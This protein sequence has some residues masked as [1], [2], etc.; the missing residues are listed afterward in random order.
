MENHFLFFWFRI[1]FGEFSKLEE[2]FV[3]QFNFFNSIMYSR[4]NNY[5]FNSLHQRGQLYVVA[6]EFRCLLVVQT[7]PEVLLV[8]LSDETTQMRRYS[9]RLCAPHWTPSDQ[10]ELSSKAFGERPMIH[11]P[12]YKLTFCNLIAYQLTHKNT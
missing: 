10:E 12:I 8:K 7:A 5:E 2:E 3:E 6:A 9:H 1:V 4:E 11:I